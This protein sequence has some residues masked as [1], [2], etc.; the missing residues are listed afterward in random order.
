MMQMD[1]LTEGIMLRRI[2]LSYPEVLFSKVL[3]VFFGFLV[4]A[5]GCGRGPEVAA[6]PPS[7]AGHW[8]DPDES[9]RIRATGKNSFNAWTIGHDLT[10]HYLT[11]EP[12]AGEPT[13]EGSVHRYLVGLI[14]RTSSLEA[15]L[16]LNDEFKLRLGR[17]EKVDG[18]LVEM[19]NSSPRFSLHGDRSMTV[20]YLIQGRTHRTPLLRFGLHEGPARIKNHQDLMT[21]RHVVHRD[22]VQKHVGAQFA[23]GLQTEVVKDVSG[24][25][26]EVFEIL[27]RDVPDSFEGRDSRGR[28]FEKLNAKSIRFLNERD[29][30][31][32]DRKAVQ[33]RIAVERVEDSHRTILALYETLSSGHSHI[34]LSGLVMDGAEGNLTVE[35]SEQVLHDDL[36]QTMRLQ[37]TLKFR[38]ASL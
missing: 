17:S 26:L 38:R 21:V 8:E 34:I 14:D 23:L 7:F 15:E 18:A 11:S 31:V 25:I 5:S 35:S 22:F 36:G 10:V 24:K 12:L 16:I 37:R 13:Q 32:N 33:F 29:A 6:N 4:F 20:T 19:L 27:P 1:L 2:F 30:L 3:P 9:S 28:M